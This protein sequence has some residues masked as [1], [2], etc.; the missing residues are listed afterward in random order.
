MRPRAALLARA[1]GR[2]AGDDDGALAA[3]DTLATDQP[4]DPY[5]LHARGRARF[6]KGFMGGGSVEDK[7]AGLAL[8][9]AA[10]E[11]A[12]ADPF[13]HTELA[14]AREWGFADA[15]GAEAEYRRALAR[16]PDFPDALLGAAALHGNP[17]ADVSADEATAWRQRAAR[18]RPEDGDNWLQLAR[19]H[20]AGGRPEQAERARARAA[21]SPGAEPDL[22]A[23]Q[24]P[25]DT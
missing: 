4:D 19:L 21:L 22:V 24:W 23:A 11:R 5:V 7:D 13:L 16:E 3:L 25:A 9:E 17:S 20:D 8:L 1:R 12:P 6:D 14:F 18:L 2:P 15:A 10:V